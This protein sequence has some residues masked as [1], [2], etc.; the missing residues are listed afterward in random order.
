ME[1]NHNP[2]VFTLKKQKEITPAM[3][4]CGGD[5]TVWQNKS[6]EKL[7]E[8]LGLPLR[9]CE[10]NFEIEY[11]KQ[12]DGYFETKFSFQSEEG[13]YVPCH[14]VVPDGA[15]DKIPVVI[16]LQGH[17]TGMHISLGRIKFDSDE[18]TISGGDRD[19]AV[20][21]LQK[22]FAALTIE[23][24]GMGMCGGT[25]KGPACQLHTMANLI[26]GRTT[27]GERVWDVSRAIDV[28]ERHFS[29]IVDTDKIICLGNSGGGTT[30]FYAACIDE[31]ISVAIPSC[32]YASFDDSISAM[33]HCTCNFVPHLRE[34]FDMGELSGLIA[35]RTLIVVSGEQD[36]I[37][38]IDSAKKCFEIA[39]KLYANTNGIC[40]HVI[41]P[42]GHRFYRDLAFK[43]FDEVVKFQNSHP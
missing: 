9:L 6:K 5:F 40:R 37:F 30:T 11:E 16:C 27:I 28:M 22:G 17:S 14:F 13:Y 21:A 26:I 18:E 8:L 20:A 29:D 33:L 38:P 12:C 23:Q 25:P 15:T 43:C 2:A 42:E 10:E 31:R 34:Y 19:F 35:P 3:R 1:R 39:C 41:G 24:R 32:A 36:D 7:T 4:Y